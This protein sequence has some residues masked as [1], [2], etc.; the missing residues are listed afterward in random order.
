M[1]CFEAMGTSTVRVQL[2][3]GEL[4]ASAVV[5]AVEKYASRRGFSDDGTARFVSIVE[6]AVAAV[7][8][9][10]PRA[11]ELIVRDEGGAIHTELHGLDPGTPMAERAR[12]DLHEAAAAI[13]EVHAIDTDPTAAFVRFEIVID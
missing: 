6:P 9:A 1:A 13:D 12:V 7:N 2:P 5:E 8:T 3:G 10:A 4:F 11:L